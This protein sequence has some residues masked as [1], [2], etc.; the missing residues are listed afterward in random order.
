MPRHTLAGLVAFI[1]MLIPVGFTFLLSHIEKVKN[2]TSLKRWNELCDRLRS[3]GYHR[4]FFFTS[5]NGLDK[6]I[7]MLLEK[8]IPREHIFVRSDEEIE[9]MS[10]SK[11]PELVWDVQN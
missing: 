10:L 2:G 9:Y 7:N 8:T 3:Q 6:A 4:H 5:H 1:S 11:E